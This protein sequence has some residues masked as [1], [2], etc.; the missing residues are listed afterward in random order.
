MA[1]MPVRTDPGCRMLQRAC[2]AVTEAQKDDFYTAASALARR[3]GDA[4]AG[5]DPSALREELLSG[6]DIPSTSNVPRTDVVHF[7]A[8]LGLGV[9]EVGA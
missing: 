1:A 4:T 8:A 5:F 7:I 3:G 2:A 9:E 6:Q